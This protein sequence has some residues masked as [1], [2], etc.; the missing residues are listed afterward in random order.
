MGDPAFLDGQE[1]DVSN[2]NNSDKSIRSGGSDINSSH[3]VQEVL[4]VHRPTEGAGGA[5]SDTTTVSSSQRTP[6]E[7]DTQYSARNKTSG[8]ENH[9][10]SS[11]KQTE[12]H[13]LNSGEAPPK[14]GTPEIREDTYYS[15]D[16]ELNTGG[17]R[18]LELRDRTVRGEANFLDEADEDTSLQDR[19]R[20]VTA[21]AGS[22]ENSCSYTFSLP[23]AEGSTSAGVAA[24]PGSRSITSYH[25]EGVTSFTDPDPEEDQHYTLVHLCFKVL[26]KLQ[27]IRNVF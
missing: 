6:S 11:H 20:R 15:V 27:E 21:V 12:E 16:R 19:R 5:T 1:N 3:Y 7:S 25:E 14:F 13:Q 22:D 18:P 10:Q 26:F 2:R 9:W 24:A 23:A 17:R 4:G 8:Q